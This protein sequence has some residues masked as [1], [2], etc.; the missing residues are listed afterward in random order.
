M[1]VS[2]MRIVLKGGLWKSTEDEILKAA[3]MKY[4]IYEWQR[5]SSLLP[6][7]TTAQVKSRWFD[8]LQYSNISQPFTQQEDMK[9]LELA[10]S[11][12]SQWKTISSFMNRPA[13]QCIDRFNELTMDVEG[14]GEKDDL[15]GPAESMEHLPA[16]AVGSSAEYAEDELNMVE[17]AK[18]RLTNTF[19]KKGARLARKRELDIQRQKQYIQAQRDLRSIGIDMSGLGEIASAQKKLGYDFLDDIVFDL[20]GEEEGAGDESGYSLS[21][22][23]EY[24]KKEKQEFDLKYK[25]RQA[26]TAKM[27]KRKQSLADYLRN[28]QESAKLHKIPELILPDPVSKEKDSGPI[29]ER[30]MRSLVDD[31]PDPLNQGPISEETRNLLLAKLFR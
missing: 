10:K 3:V 11:Y 5:I 9:L 8:Y 22:L 24:L 28:K 16:M 30:V 20:A 1:R 12:P 23:S 2:F 21:K 29:P 17:E 15:I 31:L 14:K 26:Y 6:R 19:G 27:N 4:G 13:Q 25:Q 7:K 18:S